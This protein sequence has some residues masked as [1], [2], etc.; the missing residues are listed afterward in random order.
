MQTFSEKKRNKQMIPI[1]KVSVKNRPLRELDDE[2]E[3]E[4]QSL[5]FEKG[6]WRFGGRYN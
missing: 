2:V 1:K 3:K 5:V 4:M 6:T